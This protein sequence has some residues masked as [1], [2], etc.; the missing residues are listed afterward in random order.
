MLVGEAPGQAEANLGEPFV[1]P[2]GRLLYK[3]LKE[4]GKSFSLTASDFAATNALACVPYESPGAKRGYRAPTDK[5]AENCRPRLVR[6]LRYWALKGEA[7]G[8]IL[9][10][11][12]AGKFYPSAAKQAWDKPP[13]PVLRVTHPSYWLRKGGE[14]SYE[15]FN[16]KAKIKKF[17][18]ETTLG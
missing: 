5:E 8:V 6:T 18:K 16:A 7:R 12:S 14:H 9:V 3:V 17:L 15:C 10:G 13:C 2:S 11:E 1:G 4:I